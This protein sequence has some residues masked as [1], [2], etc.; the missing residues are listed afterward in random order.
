[1][2]LGLLG[3]K[4][5]MTQFFGEDG[6]KYPVTILEVGPCSVQFIKDAERDGYGAVQLGYDDTK[7]NRLKKPQRENIK[8]KGLKP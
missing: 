8:A 4:I 3:K 5:G 6:T 7:E 1:M 2:I